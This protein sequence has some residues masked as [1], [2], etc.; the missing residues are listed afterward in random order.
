MG[1]SNDHRG[2]GLHLPGLAKSDGSPSISIVLV[3]EAFLAEYVHGTMF[4]PK[5]PSTNLRIGIFLL[6]SNQRQ[7]RTLHIQEDAMPYTFC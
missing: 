5:E 2:S 6:P 1:M 7:H 4:S 3:S